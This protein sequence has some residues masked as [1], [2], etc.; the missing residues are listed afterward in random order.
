MKMILLLIFSY[1]LGSIPFG[2]IAGR[3][4]GI[5]I[6]KTGSGNIG[7]ANVFRI[8]G[9]TAGSIVFICDFLKGTI[10]IVIAST[11]LNDPKLIVLCGILAVAGH[12][13]S[14][15]IKF[16][17]G[18]GVATTLGVLLG[19]AP[20]IFLITA[21]I[22]ILTIA[23]TRYVSVG[24]IIGAISFSILMFISKQPN[25]YSYSSLIITALI[26]YKHIPNIKRLMQGA[27]NKIGAKKT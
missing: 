14:P 18:K 21:A 10:P 7:A 22:M 25:V 2:I 27:E 13:Y 15:L 16:K 11:F 23:L 24:S 17:G 4:K 19:I 1:F 9:S 5:D 8:L 12:M 3:I 26:I 20:L 6:T